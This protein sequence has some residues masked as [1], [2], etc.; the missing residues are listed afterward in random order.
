[1]KKRRLAASLVVF[2][3]LAISAR[4]WPAWYWSWR[5]D[6]PA[7]RGAALARQDGCLSCHGPTGREETANPGS[8]WGSVP[9]FF[10]G[11]AM[12]Y[13]KAPAEIAYF[14]AEG[15]APGAA[16]ATPDA[17]KKV[18]FH[19]P[20]FGKVLSKGQ[21]DDL[22]AY[23]LAADGMSVPSEGPVSKGAQLSLKFGCESCHG[24]GGS[25][26]HSNPKSFTGSV[27]GWVGPDF[28]ELVEGRQEFGEWVLAGR[29]A[30]MRENRAASFF[31]DRA[32]LHMPA[33]RGTLSDDEVEDLW[34]YINWLRSAQEREHVHHDAR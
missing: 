6:N 11:N 10:R 2:G 9:S 20:A 32:L 4:W 24:V 7:R 16:P 18:P 23:V 13:V 3:V 28:A 12:M 17:L 14:I 1:M 21:I 31:L 8:R 15:H 34:I 29:S 30:R 22:A 26:G 33:F 19:M 25:G 27:P 5:T